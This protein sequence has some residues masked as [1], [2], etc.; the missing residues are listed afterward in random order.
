MVTEEVKKRQDK[1]TS[2]IFDLSSAIKSDDDIK[3]ATLELN[4]IYTDKFRHSYS[5]LSSTLIEITKSDYDYSL[6]NLLENLNKISDLIEEEQQSAEP[7]Y[8]NLHNAFPKIIDHFNLEIQRNNQLSESK[9]IIEEMM[10]Q[11]QLL[12]NSIERSMVRTKKLGK[13]LNTYEQKIKSADEKASSLQT[14]VIAILSIFAAIVLAFSGSISL[15]GSAL[16]GMKDAPFF[17]SVFFV[18]LCGFVI[19]NTIFVLLYFVAK[20]TGRNIYARCKSDD[21]TCEPK[22]KSIKRL[23]NRLPYVFWLNFAMLASMI[24]DLIIW[25]IVSL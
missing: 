2:C 25:G 7:K 15:L 11:N 20:I 24:L 14:E 13:K 16:V 1:L 21:C 3:K 17:K 19:S 22:C 4:E 18:L 8:K 5:S 23:C 6:E 10:V 9:M 12:Q